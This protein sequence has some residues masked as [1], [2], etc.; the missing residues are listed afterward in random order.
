MLRL[1]PIAFLLVAAAVFAGC[2]P[3]T[4]ER[5]YSIYVTNKLSQKITVFLTKNGP[6]VEDQWL[7]PAQWA[8]GPISED[9][10]ILNCAVVDPGE[11]VGIQKATGHFEGSTEAV[12]QIY[13]ATGRIADLAAIELDDPRRVDYVLNPGRNDLIVL[14]DGDGIRVETASSNSAWDATRP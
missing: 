5:T 12:L 1:I 11:M 6:P 2:A 10:K 4:Q 3:A 9:N 14:P 8:A 7:S 13:E